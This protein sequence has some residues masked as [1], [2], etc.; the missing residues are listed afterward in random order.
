MPSVC[1][2]IVAVISKDTQSLTVETVSSRPNY[3]NA[4]ILFKWV[5]QQYTLHCDL[6]EKFYLLFAHIK[7]YL[8]PSQ[9][10]LT[11]SITQKHGRP[12]CL[13]NFFE[14]HFMSTYFWPFIPMRPASQFRAKPYPNADLMLKWMSS[15]S[16]RLS[17]RYIK[18]YYKKSYPKNLWMGCPLRP[19]LDPSM[20]LAIYFPACGTTIS[21]TFDGIQTLFQHVALLC[22]SGFRY[23]RPRHYCPMISSGHL[24]S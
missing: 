23:I 6:C 8:K 21:P 12:I 15:Q 11:L 22:G 16:A 7:E 24:G 14:Q 4:L 2:Y 9:P 13:L 5:F 10:T 1:N 3:L 18:T 17:F 19:P 20:A